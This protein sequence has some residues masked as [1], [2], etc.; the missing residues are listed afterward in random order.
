[1]ALEFQKSHKSTR[2]LRGASV[3][4]GEICNSIP[5]CVSHNRLARQSAWDE[6]VCTADRGGKIFYFR[7]PQQK[8]GKFSVSCRHK[9]YII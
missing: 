9:S 2:F 4:C 3:Y 7:G 1:M 5:V 8:V 6:A